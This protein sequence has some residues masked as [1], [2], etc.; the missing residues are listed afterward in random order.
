[1]PS[2]TVAV[3]FCA[4]LDN[5]WLVTLNCEEAKDYLLREGLTLF[6]RKIKMRRYDDVLNDEYT[7]YLNYEDLQNKLFVRK[8]EEHSATTGESNPDDE[9]ETGSSLRVGDKRKRQFNTPEPSHTTL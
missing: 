4:G 2:A 3:R 6:N 7:E 9:P 8:Q 5:R 1:M